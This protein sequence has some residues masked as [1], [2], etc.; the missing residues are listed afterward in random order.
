MQ[1]NAL[2]AEFLFASFF[3]VLYGNSFVYVVVFVHSLAQIS[4]F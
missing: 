3:F 4:H 2:C 1:M